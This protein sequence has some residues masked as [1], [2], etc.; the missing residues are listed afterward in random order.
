MV[1]TLNAYLRDVEPLETTQDKRVILNSPTPL[2]PN[3]VYKY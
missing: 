1:V 2:F 3:K